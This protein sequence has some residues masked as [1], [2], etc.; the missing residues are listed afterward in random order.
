MKRNSLL[1]VI[2]L[3]LLPLLKSTSLQA[4]EITL[5]K[6][7]EELGYVMSDAN[8][9]FK[10]IKASQEG[11]EQGMNTIYSTNYKMLGG[12]HS[13]I[14]YNERTFLKYSNETVPE[15]Y[16]Y[17]QSFNEGTPAGQLLV[18]SGEMLLDAYA[19]RFDLKKKTRYTSKDKKM[20]KEGRSLSLEYGTKDGQPV[21]RLWRADAKASSETYYSTELFVYSTRKNGS[22]AGS[23][24][25]LGCMVF[26]TSNTFISVVP[27]MG[28][29]MGDPAAVAA[30]AY[31]ASGLSERDYKYEW[32]AG[33]TMDEVVDKLGQSVRPTLMNAYTV[34]D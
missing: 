8:D 15:Q 4:Q 11:R 22:V 24:K 18:D 12:S 19:K 13:Y 21:V 25:L 32:M 34:T 29:T 5:E 7:A 2:L 28:K 31:A 1:P 27:I 16:Y 6:F 30:R 14:Y 9:G 17:F 33:K 23:A 20:R 3:L 26:I 10:K